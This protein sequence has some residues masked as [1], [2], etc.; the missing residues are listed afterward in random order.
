MTDVF[1][2]YARADRNR[3][4]LIAHALTAE[5]FSVW[6][7]PEIKPGAQWNTAIRKALENAACVVTCWS[8][9]SVKSQWVA[10]ETTHGNGRQALVPMMIQDCEPP[11]PFNMMQAADLTRWRGDGSDPAWLAALDHIRRLVEAKRRM[12]AAAPP[13]GEAHGA[14]RAGGLDYEGAEEA[15]RY[16]PSPRRMGPRVGPMIM[17][18][19]VVTAV[20]TGGLWLAPQVADRFAPA[21]NAQ[22]PDL[23]APASP[24]D[25]SVNAPGAAPLDPGP[26]LG[27]PG[28]PPSLDTPTA[29]QPLPGA[30]PLSPTQTGA[31]PGGPAPTGQTP[32]GQTPRG[33]QQTLPPSPTVDATRGLDACLNRLVAMCPNANGQ[34]QGF[35]ADGRIGNPERA[36]LDGLQIASATP[37]S[38]EAAQACEGVIAQRST[39]TRR[40]G[41]TVFERACQTVAFPAP[42]QQQPTIPRDVIER[43]PEIFDRGNNSP[44][45][46]T[47]Q[48]PTRGQNAEPRAGRFTLGL[49]QW[50]NFASGQTSTVGG[51]I[52]LA[53]GRAGAYLTGGQTAQ[54]GLAPGGSASQEACRQASYSASLM[55]ERLRSGVGFCVRRTDGVVVGAQVTDANIENFS[56]SYTAWPAQ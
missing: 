4:R 37:A 50:A 17:G 46:S 2:S 47:T 12:A 45:P 9:K 28:G 15:F 19:L 10:A 38:P 30:T 56:F 22:A 7:D 26:D 35:G 34:P 5:G 18:G 6:W 32:T 20:L 44:N 13:P 3:V 29:G 36:F 49:G 54:I 39:S 14:P 51:D 11:I 16:T 43:I 55:T 41:A 27:A 31:A 53:A 48:S 8:K 1:I 33:P 52:G 24:F 21:E 42:Q 23:T 25:A 40:R